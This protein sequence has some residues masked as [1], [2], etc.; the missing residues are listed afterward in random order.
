[1]AL[2]YPQ[3]KALQSNLFE[4]FIVV[5]RL[6]HQLLKFTQKSIFSQSV[7]YLSDSDM[8]TYRSDLD[9][10]ATSISAEITLIMANDMANEE[11]RINSTYKSL[12]SLVSKEE[13][14]RRIVATKRHVLDFCSKY[15]YERPWKSTRKLGNTTLFR[16]AAKYQEWKSQV[17][18]CTLMYM[19]KLGS[20]KSVLL[21]NIVDDLNIH[22]QSKNTV[23][24]YF[25]SRHD[26]P[27]SLNART[28][29]GSL[30]RQLLLPIADLTMAAE[31][32]DET[33]S[34][35]D[36]EK[37][38]SLLHRALPSEYKAYFVLDGLDDWD[39][40]ERDML[41]QQL[42]KLQETVVL[43]LC[44][45]SRVEPS[46]ALEMSFARVTTLKITS[47]PDDNPD[48]EMFVEAQLTSCLE[49]GKL[50]VGDPGLILE[51]QDALLR[52]SHG[53]FL[54]IILSIEFL[55]ATKSDEAIRDALVDY[56]RDISETF[57]QIRRMLGGSAM[58]Y[59]RQILAS[60]TYAQRR[61]AMTKDVNEESA[62]TTIGQSDSG[63]ASA[64]YGP[65]G[66]QKIPESIED[67]SATI[68]TQQTDIDASSKTRYI[69]ELADLIFHDLAS[70]SFDDRATL[71]IHSCLESLLKT[72]AVRLAYDGSER[73]GRSMVFIHRHRQ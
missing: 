5:V 29:I 18:S 36:F 17:N 35:P 71:H 26:I 6:C 73:A 47:I 66:S 54:W 55:C 32:I 41:A 48:I 23:V 42:Q 19:G 43:H 68:Y 4:Y 7:S 53:I 50:V 40:S 14:H 13:S 62:Q 12:S 58:T 30:A 63:Y 46:S 65:Y 56:P 28:V 44:V 34:A 22:V 72:F 33:A 69:H 57:A 8:E 52:G 49:C 1:M 60:I 59:Q 9:R 20:G 10:W 15:D 2:L 27:E 61:L 25:F 3:S 31:V 64:P 39:Y 38:L 21:A 45:S 37:I 16:H 11:A 51:I 67:D 24:T 70:E